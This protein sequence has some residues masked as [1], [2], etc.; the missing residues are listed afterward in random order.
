[1]SEYQSIALVSGATRGIGRAIAA[2]LAQQGVK[3]LLGARNLEQGKKVAEALS[4]ENISIE[5]VELDTTN[6]ATI[7]R[8]VEQIGREY[9]R[10][11]ILINNA[12]ISLDFY[13]E[14]SVRE[15]LSKTLETNVVGTAALTEAVIPLLKRSQ[16]GRIVNVSSVLSSFNYR[17]QKDWIYYDVVMPTYQASKAA[18]NALTLSYAK[19]LADQNIKVN[20][21]CPGLTA[22]DAT[23]HY[24]ERTPEQAAKIAIKFALLDD[25][26][27][28]GTF[29][30]DAGSIQW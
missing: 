14:L 6:Q 16:H 8:L 9:G 22:T 17:N 3:V 18:V 26:G 10:L 13:P 2:G 5:A 23:D 4:T 12:G 19:Q 25:D 24:G 28:T 1:M 21:I 29:H 15:K 27:P 7:D 11:D 20:A 30:N